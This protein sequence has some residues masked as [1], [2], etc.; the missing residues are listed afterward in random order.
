MSHVAA[1]KA[2]ENTARKNKKHRK[3]N[4]G[5]YYHHYMRCFSFLFLVE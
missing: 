5:A 3:Y 4:E 1:T 2:T